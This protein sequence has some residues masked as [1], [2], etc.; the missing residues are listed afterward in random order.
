MDIGD[1]VE[2]NDNV[3]DID[4]LEVP[5]LSQ[6]KSHCIGGDYNQHESMTL[7][8]MGSTRKDSLH[9]EKSALAEANATGG[10]TLFGSEIDQTP[11]TR[12]S[13][14]TNPEFDQAYHQGMI[15]TM[16]MPN[17][18]QVLATPQTVKTHKQA[19]TRKFYTRSPIQQ[20]IRLDYLQ[21]HEDGSYVEKQMMVYE[22]FPKTKET[23][24]IPITVSRQQ[25]SNS[26]P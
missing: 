15:Q 17:K 8:S 20:K 9:I 24:D 11:N 2:L 16:Q 14:L 23:I 13:R 25:S 4:A 26:P 7:H 19:E 21:D 18:Q 6:L 12:K 10:T 5:Q 22:H 1:S 3:D